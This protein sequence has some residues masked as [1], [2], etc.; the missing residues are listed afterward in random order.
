MSKQG[1]ERVVE[2]ALANKSFRVTLFTHPRK[3][4]APFDITESEFIDLMGQALPAGQAGLPTG[5]AG[6]PESERPHQ[7]SPSY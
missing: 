7:K 6:L 1:M 4:C 3:A 2:K 5:Q